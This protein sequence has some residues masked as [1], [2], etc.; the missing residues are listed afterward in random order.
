MADFDSF[1]SQADDEAWIEQ[2]RRDAAAMLASTHRLLE[3]VRGF[4]ESS[5]AEHLEMRAPVLQEMLANR[6]SFGVAQ[7]QVC[8]ALYEAVG[9]PGRDKRERVERAVL[10][11]SAVMAAAEAHDAIV[12]PEHRQGSPH[13]LH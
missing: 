12:D 1:R 11:L 10:L 4:V 3:A 6:L 2:Y 8:E 5:T 9:L 7:L 13:E